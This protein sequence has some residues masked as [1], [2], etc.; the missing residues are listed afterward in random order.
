[1]FCKCFSAIF[2]MILKEWSHIFTNKMTQSEV[3][4]E[5]NVLPEYLKTSFS[6]IK[7]FINIQH[8]RIVDQHGWLQCGVTCQ[9]MTNMIEIKQA[10]R[11]CSIILWHENVSKWY[12][13][14][15]STWYS[16]HLLNISQT[17]RN[18]ERCITLDGNKAILWMWDMQ[19]FYQNAAI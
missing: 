14:W 16:K 18:E 5:K 4:K 12:Q 10:G 6:N 19:D 15:S 11:L 17:K 8:G 7:M 9:N 3:G 13:P 2:K 1:M